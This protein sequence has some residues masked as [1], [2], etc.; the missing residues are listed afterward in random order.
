V[1]ERVLVVED[2][3]SLLET[4]AYNLKREGYQVLTATDG[5]EAVEV[6]EEERPNAIILDLMLPGIDGFEVCRILRRKMSTPILMLTARVDEVD[7]VVGLEVGADDYVTKPFSTGTGGTGE[8]PAAPGTD[9][10]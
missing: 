6:A 8:G 7:R 2:E 3:P 5:L 9:D 4:L 10:P 1:K